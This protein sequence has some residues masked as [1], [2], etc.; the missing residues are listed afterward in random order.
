MPDVT[1]MTFLDAMAQA[2]LHVQLNPFH[3]VEA[4]TCP[5]HGIQGFCCAACDFYLG[6][7]EESD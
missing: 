6:L 2:N 4:A 5:E 3:Q 1:E 7:D